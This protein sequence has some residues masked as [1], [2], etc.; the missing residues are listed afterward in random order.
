[1]PD[2]PPA[3]GAAP[4]DVR[5][6]GAPGARERERGAVR[7]V[8]LRRPRRR[9]RPG[10]A[11]AGRRRST[12]R[13]S[14]CWSPAT[15]T[16]RCTRRTTSAGTAAPSSSRPSRGG[17]PPRAAARR[18]CAAPTTRGPTAST[19]GCCARRTPTLATS[20]STDFSLHPVGVETWGG[21]VFV[22]LTPERR[23]AAR[24][25]GRPGRRRRW[26]NYGLGRPGHRARR[27]DLRRR[28]QLE[29]A[30]ENYNECYHCGPVHPELSPAGAGVRRRRRGPRLGRRHPAPRGR[31]DVHDDRHHD[32]GAA[33]RARRGRSGPGTRASW[34]TRT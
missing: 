9:P 23:D 7:R 8:E 16:A 12:W 1:M 10:R 17:G 33:A 34:S 2:G 29:G 15:R 31:L 11:G 25:R 24:R 20:T 18:R 13:A 30:A 4:R 5:R 21:F 27:F 19:A 22:H 3:G 6:P 32:A 28:G 26:R 14:R